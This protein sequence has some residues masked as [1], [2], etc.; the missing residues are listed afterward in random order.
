MKAYK[1]ELLIIDHDNIGFGGIKDELENA[2]YGN[3]CICPKVKLMVEKDIGEWTDDHPLN[4]RLKCDE[5]Y[6][7]LFYS[8]QSPQYYKNAVE[9]FQ[10][11]TKKDLQTEVG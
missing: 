9:R 1:V 6:R 8:P 2:N 10:D 11:E 4:H 7:R 5:E 3:D